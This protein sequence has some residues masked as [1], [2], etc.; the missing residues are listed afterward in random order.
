MTLVYP[1]PRQIIKYR[2]GLLYD[3]IFWWNKSEGRLNK[4][5]FAETAYSG[6]S[7]I[8]K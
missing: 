1:V 7:I 4:S 2:Q 5:V 3:K 8:A 6:P